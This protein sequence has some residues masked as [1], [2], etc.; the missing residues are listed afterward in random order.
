MAS[1]LAIL[2][3]KTRVLQWCKLLKTEWANLIPLPGLGQYVGSSHPQKTESYVENCMEQNLISHLKTFWYWN[4]SNYKCIT[5]KIKF[6]KDVRLISMMKDCHLNW[7][8]DSDSNSKSESN[9]QKESF[10]EKLKSG[11]VLQ[12]LRTIN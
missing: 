6:H 8:V 7:L 3:M 4:N 5:T 2:L 1:P 12:S 9:Y 11:C 10:V